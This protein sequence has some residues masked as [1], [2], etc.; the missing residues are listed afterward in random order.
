M[1]AAEKGGRCRQRQEESSVGGQAR[2]HRPSRQEE[3]STARPSDNLPRP[4]EPHHCEL[5][6]NIPT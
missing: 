4:A 6:G 5:D 1:R 2:N 3:P